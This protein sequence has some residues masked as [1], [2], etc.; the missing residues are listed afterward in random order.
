MLQSK[1]V[2]WAFPGVQQ[3]AE[4]NDWRESEYVSSVISVNSLDRSRQSRE[5]WYSDPT[6]EEVISRTWT[7]GGLSND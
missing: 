2:N 5:V 7:T 4:E 6:C 3:V 1:T